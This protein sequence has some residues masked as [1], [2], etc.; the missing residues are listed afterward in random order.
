MDMIKNLFALFICFLTVTACQKGDDEAT[1]AGNTV[2]SNSIGTVPAS[3]TQKV[4]LELFTGAGQSQCTDGFVKAKDI[5]D[6]HPT[7]SIPVFIHY[8]DAMEI[9]YYNYV[10]SVYSTTPSPTF[11]SGMVNRTPSLSVVILNRTQW[12]SNFNQALAKTPV[13]GLAIKSSIIGNTATVEVHAGFLQALA[14]N[15][16]LNV[17]L[18]E[19]NVTG[20]GIQYDQRNAYNTTT[21]HLFNGLGD[22]ILNFQHNHVLRKMISSNGGDLIPSGSIVPGGHYVKTYTFTMGNYKTADLSIVA[23]I[24]KDGSTATSHE[25]MN[26]QKATFGN[27]KNWD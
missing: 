3:F 27:V 4:V 16:H 19:N 1:P 23:F 10:E 7:T 2:N 15:Y 9:S 18:L 6:A 8:S 22:P 20:S 17:M 14:G 13:C 5:M 12:M 26:A 25:V 24:D 11:P 21:G